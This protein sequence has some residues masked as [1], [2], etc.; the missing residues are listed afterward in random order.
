[1]VVYVFHI[2]V[3]HKL[4]YVEYTLSFLSFLFQ[5]QDSRPSELGHHEHQH[6][7]NMNSHSDVDS[8]FDDHDYEADRYAQMRKMESDNKFSFVPRALRMP[9]KNYNFPGQTSNIQRLVKTTV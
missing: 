1:M 8:L 4:F 2:F 6:S 7:D 5:A 3:V 9:M